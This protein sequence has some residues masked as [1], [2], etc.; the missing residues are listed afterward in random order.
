MNTTENKTSP[1][2][3][4]IEQRNELLT[5]LF[6]K[7]NLTNDIETTNNIVNVCIELIENKSILEI[8]LNNKTI[9]EHI[10]SILST[11]LN[12]SENSHFSNYNYKEI[13]VLLINIIRFSMTEHFVLPSYEENHE[14]LVNFN[15]DEL[16]KKIN[17]TLL[18][19]F[20]LDN[21]S[22]LVEN[23]KLEKN[24]IVLENNN[25]TTFGIKIR[26]L[27]YKR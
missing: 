5:K 12:L 14:D 15:N 25:E 20:I 9:L 23:F 8:I 2:N 22:N 7:L 18:G 26:S 27:G 4:L 10:F 11:N 16:F 19:D 6:L 21:L 3:D 24:E 17:N 1:N 13:L